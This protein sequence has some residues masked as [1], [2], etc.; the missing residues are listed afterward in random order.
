[1][2][3]DKAVHLNLN[4][5]ARQGEQLRGGIM[6]TLEELQ[7]SAAQVRE[8]VYRTAISCILHKSAIYGRVA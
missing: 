8:S 6:A 7:G 5:Q 3:K 4:C 1:M 2:Q